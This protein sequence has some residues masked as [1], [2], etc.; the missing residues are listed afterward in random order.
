MKRLH[1]CSLC[2]RHIRSDERECPFCA[3]PC[4]AAQPQP[5]ERGV[6]K[7][8]RAALFAG[9]AFLL[10]ACGGQQSKAADQ[11]RQTD[12]IAIPIDGGVPARA[13]DRNDHNH[14]KDG[15]HHDDESASELT[16]QLKREQAEREA[17]ETKQ[18]EEQRLRDAQQKQQ[19]QDQDQ[20]RRDWENRRR[21]C[22]KNSNGVL[23]CPPYGAPSS[24]DDVVV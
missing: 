12:R 7:I 13:I 21:P 16:E 18:Q 17:L 10:P 8:T 3:T 6:G 24:I 19:D 14:R 23:V 4:T 20:D 9:A 15:D 2:R 11:N 22:V 1:P 5:A